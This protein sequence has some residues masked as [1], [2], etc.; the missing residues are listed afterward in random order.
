MREDGFT[1]VSRRGRKKKKRPSE[2]RT[3][4]IEA[5]YRQLITDDDSPIDIVKQTD[6]INEAVSEI[7][8]SSLFSSLCSSLP[9]DIE[10]LRCYGL[11]RVSS[12]VTARFQLALLLALREH[13]R[14]DR[15]TVFDPVFTEGDVKLLSSL[16]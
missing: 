8:R 16:S 15:V 13:L 9:P 3:T 4:I 7:V 10:S 6:K 1:I 14:L 12:C 11:G 2:T 5:P